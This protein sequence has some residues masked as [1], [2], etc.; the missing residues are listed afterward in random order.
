MGLAV[1]ALP[2]LLL[3]LDNSV[4]FLALPHL[5]ADLHPSGPQLLWIM[6]IYGFMIAGFLI[7][8][9]T[10]GDRIGRRRLLLVG[11]AAFGVASVFA[12]YSTS[13]EMLIVARA[14]LGVAAATMTPS[15]L[16]LISN[17]F[18]DPKQRAFAI[19]VWMACF[20]GGTIIGPVVG[21]VLL[22]S[23]WWGSVFLMG[24]PVMA[25][26]L[27]LG[28]ALLPE[29]RD[30]LAG[31][32][33]LT[34]MAMS[35]GAV[36]PIIYGLKELAG[37]GPQGLSALS[38]VAG[39]AVGAA[40]VRRQRRLSDP[41]L[42]L[43]LLGNRT[44]GAALA[45][46]LVGMGIVGGIYLV[47]TQY[48]QLV[49]GLSPL[50]AGLWMVPAAVGEMG[51]A[52]LA[53]LIARR[54]PPASVVGAGLAIS[55]IGALMLTQV[56]S[57]LQLAVLVTGVVVVFLGTS[58]MMVL[59]TDV[60][61]ESAPPEKGG[62]AASMLETSG[63]FGVAMGVAGLGSI[64]TAIYRNQIADSVPAAVPPEAADAAHNTLASATDVAGRLPTGIAAE[65]LTS[66]RE[67]FT[68]ALN[69][70]AGVSA[71]LAAVLAVVA[72][73]VLRHVRPSHEA[74]EHSAELQPAGE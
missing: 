15:T 37:G 26:L 3:A 46:L 20:S 54:V 1:L 6:D 52:M 23:F 34:S 36:L 17:L 74:T 45:I 39:V 62:A 29:Y 10:L 65:L 27:V 33:D 19:G 18:Q 50:R 57:T 41:L 28:P 63:E 25:L 24:V 11:A 73:T 72:V 35:L 14:L 69:T 4:L 68:T 59:S 8:M 60:V 51:V 21:G 38:I 22:E 49:A 67:A 42:D 55:A 2:V 64:G 58:P 30:T 71:V 66:A 12:A 31:R 53:P 70:V 16:A 9:G 56:G 40:F 13:A 5:D 61:V 47:V 7:T 43:R 48:L 32:L 44:F